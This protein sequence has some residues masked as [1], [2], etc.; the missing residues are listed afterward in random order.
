MKDKFFLIIR[1]GIKPKINHFV[2]YGN[3][4]NRYAKED[5]S[6]LLENENVMLKPLYNGFFTFYNK[7]WNYENVIYIKYVLLTEAK[8]WNPLHSTVQTYCPHT[9]NFSNSYLYR[10]ACMYNSLPPHVFLSYYKW[11]T[12]NET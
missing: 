8:R 4:Y 5:I 3:R 7:F 10:T 12:S 11:D 6:V 9:A 1:P 2:T